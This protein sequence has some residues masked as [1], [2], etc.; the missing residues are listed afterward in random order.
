MF[1]GAMPASLYRRLVGV[2]RSVPVIVLQ[3]S[4]SKG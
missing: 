2:G 1:G 4:F 3:V